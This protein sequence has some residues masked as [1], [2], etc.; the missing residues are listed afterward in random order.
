MK[1]NNKKGFTITELVIVIA[2]IAILAAVLIPTFSGVIKKAK[3]SN[4]TQIAANLSKEINWYTIEYDVDYDDLLGTDVKSL[5]GIFG[6]DLVPATEDWTFVWDKKEHVVTV[7][8]KKEDSEL[9]NATKLSGTPVDPTDMFQNYYL[10]GKGNSPLE[11]A[12]DLLCNLTKPEDYNTALGYL[13]GTAFADSSDALNDNYE[14]LLETFDP[15]YTIYLGSSAAITSADLASDNNQNTASVKLVYLEGTFHLSAPVKDAKHN[16]SL[17]NAKASQVI[18]S[19]EVGEN[20]LATLIANL[21]TST[22]VKKMDLSSPEGVAAAGLQ[23]LNVD[24]MFRVG[25]DENGDPE[26]RFTFGAQV[27]E[28]TRQEIIFEG[29][30]VIVKYYNETGLFAYGKMDH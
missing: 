8:Q 15:N 3:L 30:S 26:Y 1:R 11:R 29:T 25:E 14:G 22:Y 9:F 7:V 10:I 23:S 5:A 12:V 21:Y 13:A 16:F 19:I 17:N 6:Y 4:D 24:E 27:V 18:R 2:V 28:S 20:G